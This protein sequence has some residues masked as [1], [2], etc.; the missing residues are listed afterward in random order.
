M[1]HARVTSPSSMSLRSDIRIG[2]SSDHLRFVPAGRARFNPFRRSTMYAA[3][4]PVN[5]RAAKEPR[6]IHDEFE[7]FLV[8]VF[9]RRYV[10]YC[11]RRRRFAQMN[12]AA[13]LFADVVVAD[14]DTA[15]T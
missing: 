9:L 6:S 11:A 10:T 14:G 4:L 1:G 7:R 13:R 2:R 12:E 3:H 5:E 8:L 15:G